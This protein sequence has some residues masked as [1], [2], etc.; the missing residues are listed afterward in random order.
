MNKIN[1]IENESDDIGFLEKKL[2][3]QNL[4]LKIDK[5]FKLFIKSPFLVEKK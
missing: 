1:N 2:G 3:I 4:I 5:G